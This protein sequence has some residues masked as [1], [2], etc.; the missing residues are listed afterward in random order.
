MTN[1][2]WLHSKRPEQWSTCY[3]TQAQGDLVLS[4]AFQKISS[5]RQSKNDTA[6]GDFYSCWS[7]S[8]ASYRELDY[9]CKS[10]S[11]RNNSVI[12]Y[13]PN[14]TESVHR[15]HCHAQIF[16]VLAFRHSL[17]RANSQHFHGW[18]SDC[19]NRSITSS[20]LI[21]L[22]WV[23]RKLHPRLDNPVTISLSHSLAC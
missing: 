11:L 23:Q 13:E 3:R 18:R 7:S 2:N 1:R 20:L 19:Q 8:R 16:S 5:N 21:C 9:F 4:V 10:D 6:N 14:S 15:Y 22:T 12:F 17:T